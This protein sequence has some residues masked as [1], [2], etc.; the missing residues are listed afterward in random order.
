MADS[1]R[2][3]AVCDAYGDHHT[4]R[5]ET[6]VRAGED[7]DREVAEFLQPAIEALHD[8]VVSEDCPKSENEWGTHHDDWYEDEGCPWCGTTEA[9]MAVFGLSERCNSLIGMTDD[10]AMIRCGRPEDDP[11]HDPLGPPGRHTFDPGP[12]LAGERTIYENGQAQTAVPS[13][14]SD[15]QSGRN[16]PD[17]T[18]S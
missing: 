6:F 4:D 14:A 2:W 12:L 18:Q 13:A 17:Q 1:P 16:L 5:H 7:E 11:L 10:E 8:I 9:N 15:E 3:C